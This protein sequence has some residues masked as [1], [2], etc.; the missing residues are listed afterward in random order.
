[1]MDTH[2]LGQGLWHN[3]RRLPG[4]HKTGLGARMIGLRP[5]GQIGTRRQFRWGF[6]RQGLDSVPSQKGCALTASEHL[7]KCGLHDMR[8]QHACVHSQP[9]RL[10]NLSVSSSGCR[11][12]Q[13]SC[14][15]ENLPLHCSSFRWSS[16]CA[17]ARLSLPPGRW[18]GYVHF[19]HG[20]M[21]TNWTWLYF[22][23]MYLE[24]LPGMQWFH[25]AAP[26]SPTMGL[27]FHYDAVFGLEPAHLGRPKPH[28]APS[29]T[30]LAFSFSSSLIRSTGDTR[31]HS[32]RLQ[33]LCAR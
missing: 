4:S 27:D 1:M 30:P 11:Q 2:S 20:M 9:V 18:H 31:S 10:F 8:L 21:Q 28:H 25:A 12:K 13:L 23:Y 15:S 24:V 26:F 14:K 6:R 16:M 17:H 22:T 7:Y 5:G 32:G 29:S 19:C 33:E 3:G